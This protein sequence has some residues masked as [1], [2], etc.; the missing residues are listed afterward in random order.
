LKTIMTFG[1][2]LGLLGGCVSAQNS[3]PAPTNTMQAIKVPGAHTLGPYSKAV[4][5]GDFVF[6]SGVV[7]FDAKAG[8]F[9]DAKIEPQTRQVFAN[10]SQ[11]LA[12]ANLSLNDVVKTTVFLK[13]PKDF[14]PMNK[15]YAEYFL[16]HKPARSTVPG[17]DWD[18]PEILIEI[19]VVAYAPRP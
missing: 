12:A 2:T 17:M 18:R 8:A 4:R 16:A 1:L 7:A 9:V 15:V 11:V 10:I 5:A 19:E 3:T 14:A 6:L 13:D